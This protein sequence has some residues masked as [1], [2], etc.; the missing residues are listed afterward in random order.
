[1]CSGCMGLLGLGVD[2]G[3]TS[4]YNPPVAKAR[5]ERVAP[6]MLRPQ[7]TCKLTYNRHFRSHPCPKYGPLLAQGITLKPKPRTTLQVLGTVALD[8]QSCCFCFTAF[9]FRGRLLLEF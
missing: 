1:M 9:V 5:L 4:N 2:C 8:G 3:S 7:W 6:D